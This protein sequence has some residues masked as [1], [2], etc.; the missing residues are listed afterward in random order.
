MQQCRQ[1]LLQQRLRKTR[2]SHLSIFAFEPPE[3]MGPGHLVQVPKR[4][5]EC[6]LVMGSELVG[7][8]MLRLSPTTVLVD[9]AVDAAGASNLP[10]VYLN[11]LR[12]PDTEASG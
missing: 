8:R 4:R 3:V 6:W 12:F 5:S 9:L 7:L 10:G 2:G 1:R 11:V